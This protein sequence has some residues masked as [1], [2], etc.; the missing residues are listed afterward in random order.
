MVIGLFSRDYSRLGRSQRSQRGLLRI[1]F[2]EL[3]KPPCS[4]CRPATV[5]K[6]LRQETR[7]SL[8]NMPWRGWSPKTHPSPT[9]RIWSFCVEGC[10]QKWGNPENCGPARC[11]TPLLHVGCHA[12]FDRCWSNGTSV[13]TE[14]PL[15][16]WVPCLPHFKVTEGY[17][18]W[19]G[20][21]GYPWLPV[22]SSTVTVGL[23]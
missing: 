10:R 8:S 5:S 19:D 4:P 18:N 9:C 22:R 6:H 7:L 2:R 3:L 14:I 13:R 17:R 11:D 16:N 15:E 1:T 23:S 12:Q 20:E 21:I